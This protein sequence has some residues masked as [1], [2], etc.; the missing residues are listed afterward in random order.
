MW[1]DILLTSKRII[2]VPSGRA[3][4]AQSI[5]YRSIHTY[6]TKNFIT[7]DIV[8]TLGGAQLELSFKTE[9]ERAQ[10]VTLLSRYAL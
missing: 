5:P 9:D 7:K 3:S 6:A 10:A 2:V 4:D 8:L 1:K